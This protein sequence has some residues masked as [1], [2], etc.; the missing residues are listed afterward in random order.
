MFFLMSIDLFVLILKLFLPIEKL[1]QNRKIVQ[2][3]NSELR[4]QYIVLKLIL[5]QH[6]Y[7]YYIMPTPFKNTNAIAIGATNLARNMNNG[8]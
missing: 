4:L 7:I 6:I 5:R 1:P 8:I 3:M 2:Y